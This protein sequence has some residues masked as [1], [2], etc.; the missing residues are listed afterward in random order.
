MLIDDG[1]D[2]NYGEFSFVKG[3]NDGNYVSS[4]LSSCDDAS[5]VLSA[6]DFQCQESAVSLVPTA[7]VTSATRD[8]VEEELTSHNRSCNMTL[9]Q[10]LSTK[11]IL[12]L[13]D[14]IFP[15]LLQQLV[16]IAHA[17]RNLGQQ[18]KTWDV[19]TA[20][21][22][23]AT[24]Q[25][26]A[27]VYLQASQFQAAKIAQRFGALAI[28]AHAT[29]HLAVDH[30]VVVGDPPRPFLCLLHPAKAAE[31]LVDFLTSSV[32]KGSFKPQ[33][34][35]EEDEDRIQQR[36]LRGV[37]AVKEVVRTLKRH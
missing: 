18:V 9:G 32:G 36:G 16:N 4:W 7:V 28:P 25:C 21:R 29:H 31:V 12:I 26:S 23:P 14:T 5:K 8:T 24:S 15:G 27:V 34:A 2:D 13:M 37:D 3:F 30:N 35:V 20:A 10:D 22:A 1:S 33:H 17:L 11:F 19:N 6:S